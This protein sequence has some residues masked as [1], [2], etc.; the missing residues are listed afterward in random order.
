M[1]H[2]YLKGKYK[3]YSKLHFIDFENLLLKKV[4]PHVDIDTTKEELKRKN[5]DVNFIICSTENRSIETAQ[6]VKEITGVEF[7]VSSLLDEVNF[8]KGIIAENDVSDFNKSREIILTNIFH[9]NHSENFDVIK[10]RF[11]NF[12]EYIRSL[13]HERILCVTH[14]WF[15]R[16][17]D[18]Y[19]V[20]GS[21]D[22]QLKELLEV[23]VPGFLDTVEISQ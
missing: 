11:L 8:T 10:K 12:L 20:K 16:L 19:S 3:D 4:T 1:R 13:D 15:M 9:S 5:L 14:G 23:K 21:L 2:G 6:I 22:I 7:E 17:I 18:I